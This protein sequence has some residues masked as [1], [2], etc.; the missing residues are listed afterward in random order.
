M[1]IGTMERNYGEKEEKF[2][3]LALYLVYLFFLQTCV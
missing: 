2:Q 3:Q 1:T